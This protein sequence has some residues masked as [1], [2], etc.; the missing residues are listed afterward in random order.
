MEKKQQ[1]KSV[2]QQ[3]KVKISEC[4]AA[5][6]RMLKNEGERLVNEWSSRRQE[7]SVDERGNN[8]HGV[9]IV[10]VVCLRLSPH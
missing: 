5:K 1:Q 4:L 9:L 8:T 7:A 2:Y 10:F 6:I 3:Q